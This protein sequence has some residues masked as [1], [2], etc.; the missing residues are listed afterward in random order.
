MSVLIMATLLE[1][2][3]QKADKHKTKHGYFAAENIDVIRCALP[4][5][6][7]AAAPRV[8][9]DTKQD[10]TEIAYNMCSSAKEKSRFRH[11]CVRAKE[12]GCKLIF[13]IEDAKYQDIS[14]LYGTKIFLHNGQVISGDQLATAMHVMTERYGCEYR[15][16]KPEEAGEQIMRILEDKNDK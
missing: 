4:F 5:G 2:T 10:V 7:Y 1:D 11:E 15:F 12:A 16:C 3:R 13:L 9:V 6:D 14:S 8:A